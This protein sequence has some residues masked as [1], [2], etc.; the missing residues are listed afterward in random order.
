METDTAEGLPSPIIPEEELGANSRRSLRVRYIRV[1]MFVYQAGGE[2]LAR[3]VK[4]VGHRRDGSIKE[5][6]LSVH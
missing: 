2:I 1:S 4:I 5:N 3:I 6:E